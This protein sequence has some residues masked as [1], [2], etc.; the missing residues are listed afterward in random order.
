MLW[1]PCFQIWYGKSYQV[2]MYYLDQSRNII[3]ILSVLND[4]DCQLKVA[5]LMSEWGERWAVHSSQFAVCCMTA[6]CVAL[7]QRVLNLV[8]FPFDFPLSFIMYSKE[9]QIIINHL[10]DKRQ[11]SS[12]S[13]ISSQSDFL[14]DW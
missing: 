4:A 1:I 14:S 7:R 11:E 12:E 2:F 6:A 5:P 3:M 10:F 13:S 8:Y 9:V